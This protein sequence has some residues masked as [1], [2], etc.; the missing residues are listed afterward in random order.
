MEMKTSIKPSGWSMISQREGAN[1]Q[2]RYGDLLIC[3]IFAENC[4]I[5]KE[6]GLG[7]ASL[8]GQC[9]S[10]IHKAAGSLVTGRSLQNGKKSMGNRRTERP[11]D[12][13]LCYA[14][15]HCQRVHPIGVRDNYK[16]AI[17]RPKPE[18][19]KFLFRTSWFS[20]VSSKL[21]F[22]E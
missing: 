17:S 20:I 7:S 9:N 11:P 14:Q 21:K 6:F 1:F 10:P 18:I 5:M 8:I 13:V 2:G 16:L 22:V 19:G 12:P 3:K 4:M 15:E